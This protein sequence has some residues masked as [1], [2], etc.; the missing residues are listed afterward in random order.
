[1]CDASHNDTT[2]MHI[3]RCI[4]SAPNVITT[5]IGGAVRSIAVNEVDLD[6][7]SAVVGIHRRLPLAGLIAHNNDR[8][9]TEG[10]K[11]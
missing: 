4:E 8:E 1:M 3:Q 9:R 10:R 2:L 6:A 11:L 7:V 5:H